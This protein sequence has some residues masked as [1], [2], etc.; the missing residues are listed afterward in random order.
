MAQ[1]ANQLVSSVT[2][3]GA[4]GRFWPTSTLPKVI[5]P[6]AGAPL[7]ARYLPMAYNTS[8]NK[9]VPWTSGGANGTGTIKGFLATPHQSHATDDT[10]CAM[11]LSGEFHFAD[12]PI[13]TGEDGTG[14]TL[15]TAMRGN[16]RGIGF[17]VQGL[18]DER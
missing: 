10:L 17:T 9:W 15:K 16:M 11:H 14:A 1:N 3:I 7:L 12:I 6:I 5:A 8:T 4:T 18:T 13:P 2:S